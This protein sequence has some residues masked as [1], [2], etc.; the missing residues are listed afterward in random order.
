M[1]LSVIIVNWNTK[2]L[3]EDCLRSIF[4][5]TKNVSFEVVVVDNG[6][7]DGS[8]AMVKKKFPQVKLIPNKDNLGFAKASNQGIKLATGKY[9]L[10]L[11]SDTYLIENSFKKLLDDARSLG[12]KLGAMGP[13]LLNEDR[14]IQQSV[15]FFPNIPQIFWWMTFFDDLPGGTFLKPY[16]VDH[17]SFYK[18]EHEVDWVTGAVFLI[19]KKVIEKAGML[20]EKIFMY[21]EDFEWCFRIKK[22][23]FKVY[24]S[25]AAKIVHIGGGSLKK[26]RTRA[27]IGEFEGIKYFYSKHKDKTS[28]QIL[29]L[30]LK[31]GAL[32][33]IAVFWLLGRKELAKSYVE[34]FKVA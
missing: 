27:Y 6:S 19:P 15:G 11:N 21:G 13:L 33:R 9:I 10:L 8:Q 5:F 28:L 14:S 25:P 31:M 17:D 7:S 24:F 23:G 32:L 1:D 3:L 4:K 26:V 2:K 16:H 30:L 20:D 29:R 34:V 12:E 18:S 22:A